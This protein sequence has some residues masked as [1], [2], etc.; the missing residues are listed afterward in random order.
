LL[1][2]SPNPTCLSTGSPTIVIH[3]KHHVST[4]EHARG[5]KVSAGNG[6]RVRQMRGIR[7]D[8]VGFLTAQMSLSPACGLGPVTSTG[9]RD[10][11]ARV[12]ASK[13]FRELRRRSCVIKARLA[14]ALASLQAP[15]AASRQKQHPDRR[16]AARWAG[17]SV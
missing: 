4:I 7:C 6:R 2:A 9:V 14:A 16:A 5:N 3:R 11:E 1:A 15:R 10:S 13:V 8:D 12:Q 17:Y